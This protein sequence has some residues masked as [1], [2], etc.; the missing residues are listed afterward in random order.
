[1]FFKF[2]YYFLDGKKMTW[3]ENFGSSKIIIF[4][5]K[6]WKN[7]KKNTKFV[8]LA[9]FDMKIDEQFGSIISNLKL[10]IWVRNTQA[11]VIRET[12]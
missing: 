2:I 11:I 10:E 7:S 9:R 8:L 12:Q 6:K 4:S 3:S 1:M 5:H